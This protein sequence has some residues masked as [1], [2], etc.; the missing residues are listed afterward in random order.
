MKSIGGKTLVGLSWNILR[1]CADCQEGT[2]CQMIYIKNTLN[3]TVFHKINW[4]K[5]II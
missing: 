5:S 4:L 1:Y 2:G 3:K